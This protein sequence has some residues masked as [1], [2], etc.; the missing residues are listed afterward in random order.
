[1]GCCCGD[2]AFIGAYDRKFEKRYVKTKGKVRPKFKSK[3]TKGYQ[4]S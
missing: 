3:H 2:I 1:M 4:Q